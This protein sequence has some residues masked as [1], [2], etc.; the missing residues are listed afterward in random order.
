MIRNRITAFLIL[1]SLLALLALP[2]L[3][4]AGDNPYEQPVS[5]GVA[6]RDDG[7]LIGIYGKP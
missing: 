5:F 4:S 7:E 2:A 6:H 1:C 3:A